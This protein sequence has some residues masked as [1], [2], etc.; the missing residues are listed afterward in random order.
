[1]IRWGPLPVGRDSEEKGN[2]T[3]RNPPQGVSDSG[4]NRVS[5]SWDLTLEDKSPWLVGGSV[6]LTA[7]LWKA[8]TTFLRSV[9]VFVF[10]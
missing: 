4:T 7:E 6:G 8:W 5:M 3:G 2:C 10:T 1:M 9:Y